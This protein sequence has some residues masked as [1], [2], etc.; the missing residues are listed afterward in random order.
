LATL[1]AILATLTLGSLFQLPTLLGFPS[2]E[3]LLYRM[4]HSRF[5]SNASAPALFHKTLPGLVPA[6]QRLHPTSVA[7]SLL[8]P[9]FFPYVLRPLLS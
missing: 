6:L 5:P 4:I 3:L 8:E 1:S 7:D 9:R 2:S